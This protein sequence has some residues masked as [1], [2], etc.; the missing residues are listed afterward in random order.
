MFDTREGRTYSE[1]CS[2]RCESVSCPAGFV[3]TDLTT[4]GDPEAPPSGKYCVQAL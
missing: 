1:Y 4:N 2:A 3:C